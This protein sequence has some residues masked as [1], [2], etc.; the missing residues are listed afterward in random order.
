MR[1]PFGALWSLLAAAAVLTAC[2]RRPREPA[3]GSTR[4]VEPTRSPRQGVATGSP[5]SAA[6]SD[7]ACEP[8]GLA[9]GTIAC[10]PSTCTVG[11]E[12]CCVP[13][14]EG[15]EAP[16]CRPR[17]CDEQFP[18]VAPC[19]GAGTEFDIRLCDDSSDCQ[20]GAR[21]CVDLSD[22]GTLITLCS[23]EPSSE[24]EGRER[25]S[26]SSCRTPGTICAPDGTC[27]RPVRKVPCGSTTCMGN[28]AVCCMDFAR[29]TPPR[30]VADRKG[31]EGGFGYECVAPKDCP[32]MHCCGSGDGQMGTRC[33]LAC[34]W[35]Q[36]SV[37]CRSDADCPPPPPMLPQTAKARCKAATDGPPGLE[38]CLFDP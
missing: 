20:D 34:N 2:P 27:M 4:Y 22:G 15:A 18:L 28:Q 24:C 36:E 35:I 3:G 19:Q 32:G 37:A 26:G 10:G 33:A 29:P 16:V 17:V 6:A 38:F 5:S 9:R 23:V 11:T 21:C 8:A 1:L 25:C 13:L 14:W 31:C 7:S 30:C 12:V